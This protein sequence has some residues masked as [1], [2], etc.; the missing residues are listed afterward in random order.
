MTESFLN[1]R[2]SRCR[3]VG[4]RQRHT[5]LA[6][7]PSLPLAPSKAWNSPLL[8]ETVLSC[9][10]GM[11]LP[12]LAPPW[13]TKRR[14]KGC[15]QGETPYVLNSSNKK[16]I[17][18]LKKEE[19]F[20][21]F[22]EELSK[23]N[24]DENRYFD[25]QD[26]NMVDSYLSEN[27]HKLLPY[28][29]SRAQTLDDNNPLTRTITE[30][31]KSIINNFKDKA[32]GQSGVRKTVMQHLPDVAFTELLMPK[33]YL[34]RSSKK[35]IN[36]RIKVHIENNVLYNPNQYGVQKGRGTQK[37][38][39]SIYE[40]IAI[41][42]RKRQQC[43]IVCRD[44][45]KAFD[46]LWK[47]GFHFK[48]LHMNL[49][50]IMEKMLCNFVEDRAAT[51]R[52]G[53]EI[54]PKFPLLSGVPQGSIVSP[55][56]FIFYKADAERPRNNCAEVSFTDGNIQIIMYVLATMT[57]NEIGNINAF[58]KSGK[59]KA[60][61]HI[62]TTFYLS[63]KTEGRNCRPSFKNKVTILGMEFGTRGV[64]MHM[65]RRSAMANCQ[66]TKLK[67]FGKMN[68]KIQLHFYKTLIRPILED[69][70]IPL[71]ISSK[72][73]IIKKQQFQNRVIRTARRN[74]EDNLLST[75]D[76]HSK[77]KV[78]PVNTRLL[79]EKSGT[80]YRSWTKS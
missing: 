1:W 13:H 64:S 41:L 27:R 32:P 21:R 9:L 20:R 10:Y 8:H 53:N 28:S 17:E 39:T 25:G 29:K 68:S 65:K 76:L 74:E 16:I 26:E 12:L 71:C 61:K 40:T 79:Q 73:N 30:D 80:N 67:R 78:E 66:Y 31:I 51:I 52:S 24:P 3:S 63:N 62:S 60:I 37:A 7:C 2:D 38:I 34:A 33:K 6:N 55:T 43:N 11:K 49:Q 36:N 44:R 14:L 42:Q 57:A 69:P 50:D 47:P 4:P 54:G 45:A 35:N 19:A 72:T 15:S 75:A 48:I 58:E 5:F 56:L 22:R 59:S 70:A 77:Y 18:D 23:I 46:K